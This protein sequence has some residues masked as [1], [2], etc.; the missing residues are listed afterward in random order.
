MSISVLNVQL[1]RPARRL[2]AAASI[3]AS[4]FITAACGSSSGAAGGPP[5]AGGRGG[6]AMAVPVEM[7]TLAERP[8][9]QTSEFVGTVRSRR[10][11]TV[12]PQVEGFIKRIL[13]K[14][15]DRVKAGAVLVEIDDASQL[16][17][18]AN[19]ESVK[20]A[21]EADATFARQQAERARKLLATGAISQQEHD[22]AQALQ[23][24][25]EAQLKAVEE[26]IR[27]Q[28]N[29]WSY[30]R[31]TAAA[32]GVVGDVPVR[33]GD[34]VT[35]TTLITTVEDNSNLELYVNVPVHEAPRLKV[36]LTVQVL[37]DDGA[38]AATERINFISPSV[39]DATQTVL[40][41]TP[42]ASRGGALRTDQS[43]RARIV[44]STAPTLT[45]PL[46][47]VSRI[48]GQYFV[49]VAEPGEGGGLVARQRPMTVGPLVGNDYVVMGGLKAGDKVIVAGVQKIGDGA[50]VAPGPP[51]GRGGPPNGRGGN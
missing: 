15:G 45:V 39:D 31:V 48:S 49:F 8:V 50:P 6:P 41:K 43:V 25:T 28:K 21:R 37:N 51:G 19:L 13:V 12:Q 40:V 24:S 47:A 36:G 33:V 42:I 4:L 14:S 26:Q 17:I 9:D 44:W 38:V 23:R 5:G 2:V 1:P 29:E 11:V 46:V 16:A 27:Q 35:R 7:L 18:V 32:D 20:A 34:R 30:T 10:S 3:A 22:Q